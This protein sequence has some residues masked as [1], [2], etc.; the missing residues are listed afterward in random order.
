MAITY[1]RDLPDETSIARVTFRAASAV[2]AYTSPYT[3]RTQRQAR[4]GFVWGGEVSTIPLT[5]AK[6][7]LWSAWITSMNGQENT[8]YMGDM[9]Q[10]TAQGEAGGTPLVNGASQTGTSL[11]ID[12]CTISQT[13]WLK[14]GDYFS[15]GSSTSK[16]L[17]KCLEDADTDAGGNVT[18]N[19]WPNLRSSP[20]N[21]DALDITNPRTTCILTE[22]TAEWSKA[23]D[24]FTR[25]SFEYVEALTS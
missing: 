13:A 21:N 11:I 6:A 22:N 3:F 2:A 12:G 20:A 16:R 24:H 10:Q 19:I 4:T 18:L 15:L 7:A 1:P 5:A 8:F 9:G 17:Y 14:A 25:L 23:G